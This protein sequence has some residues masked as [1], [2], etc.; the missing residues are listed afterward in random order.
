MLRK[1]GLTAVTLN[2][3]VALFN[4]QATTPILSLE[5]ARSFRHTSFAAMASLT[6]AFGS[7]EVMIAGGRRF[8]GETGFE[9]PDCGPSHSSA[10]MRTMC[11]ASCT[12]GLALGAVRGLAWSN[13]TMGGVQRQTSLWPLLDVSW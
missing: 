10:A 5:S 13:I 4:V 6:F 9:G 1:L 12:Q 3:A 8:H 7:R 11:P 2:H